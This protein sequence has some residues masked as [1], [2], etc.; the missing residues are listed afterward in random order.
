MSANVPA[1]KSKLGLAFKVLGAIIVLPVV[2]VGALLATFDADKYRGEIAQLLTDKLGRK[3]S[4]D[5]PMHLGVTHGLALEINNAA[6][7]NP[8]WASRPEMAKVG[9]LSLSLK[10]A[11]LLHKELAIDTIV[12][13]D[14]DVQLETGKDGAKNWEFEML[15]SHPVKTPQAAAEEKLVA[16][17]DAKEHGK[18][19]IDLN[20]NEIK[21]KNIRFALHDAAKGKDTV[22]MIANLVLNAAGKTAL[23]LDGAFN[24]QPFSAKIDGAPWQDLL[25]NKNWPFQAEAAFAGNDFAG[26]GTLAQ[27]GTLID[28]TSFK[29]KTMIGSTVDGKLNINVLAKPTI[30]GALHIDT[31]KPP[32][33]G[34]KSAAAATEAAPSTAE[35][36]V[37][38]VS[39]RLFSDAKIDLASLKAANANLAI[40]I[41]TIEAGGVQVSKLN[42][43]LRLL[44]GNLELNPINAE[45]AGNAI[46]GHVGLNA[47]QEPA[48]LQVALAGHQMDLNS[49]LKSVGSMGVTL[50]KSDLDVDLRSHGDSAHGFASNL[51]GKI[52][53]QTGKGTLPLQGLKLFASGLIRALLPGA[54]A[55]NDLSLTCGTVRFQAQNGVLN[56][57][58]ILL[59]SNLTTVV[60]SG[61]IDLGQENINLNLKPQP[62][63][64][65]LGR[66]APNVRMAGSL[67]AP[68]IKIDAASSVANIAGEFLGNNL[69][70]GNTGMQVPVVNPNAAGNPCADALDHPVYAT[71]NAAPTSAAGKA[72]EKGRTFVQ[73]KL[74]KVLGGD[75]NPLKGLFGQ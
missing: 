12:L 55:V 25:T 36:V 70:I 21:L 74:G 59:E 58:G 41:D 46:A 60:G 47:A 38:P 9:K 15:K 72:V 5:G 23:K 66:L 61:A 3:V 71:T 22:V 20:V 50:G 44:G 28:L 26:Q 57:N 4:L 67:T 75:K 33:G 8:E 10:L 69:P 63:D 68:A 37:V 39:K 17:V 30:N 2:G 42:T 6:V 14:A 56:S 73:E 24:Q 19:P 1:K 32:A 43:T 7:A 48:A 13:N 31:I 54:E 27:L 52:V 16:K 18:L 49:L 35:A 64:G 29:L 62:K 40:T 11:P 45:V 34:S 53:V 51:D 65:A